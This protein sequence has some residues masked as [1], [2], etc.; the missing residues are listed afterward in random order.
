M[1]GRTRL[2]TGSVGLAAALLAGVTLSYWSFAA[3]REGKQWAVHDEARPKPKVVTPGTESTQQQP[4][5]APSDAVVLFDGKDLSKWKASRG[6]G[7]PAWKVEDGVLVVAGGGDIVTKEEFGD[8]QLHVE[9]A[10]PT[11]A[12]GVGQ[13]RGN[14]GVKIMG[15]YEVQIIDSYQ[16]ETYADGQAGAL[17]GQYPPLVNA[18]RPPGQW[19]AYDIIFHAPK[20]DADGKVTKP[21]TAT[22]L[23]NGVL[24]QDHAEL[25]GTTAHKSPGVYKAHP[26]KLPLLLQDHRNPVRYRNIWVRPLSDERP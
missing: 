24:V 3:E 12:G 21:A 5:K 19:Q 10:S 17:Y 9:W 7:E 26:P 14:S 4:G 8:C 2:R 22:V 6:G 16:A 18:S 20:F 1:L 13:G 15:R 11:P 23:H 25:K